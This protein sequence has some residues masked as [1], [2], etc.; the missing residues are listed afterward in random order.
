VG[1][2]F[3]FTGE[4]ADV[5]IAQLLPLG[6]AGWAAQLDAMSQLEFWSRPIEAATREVAAVVP[7]II[8]A[9]VLLLAVLL[10]YRVA[11]RVLLSAMGKRELDPGLRELL[12]RALK[13]SVMGFGVTLAA[14]QAGV[15][16]TA[17]LAGFSMAGT[18]V[19]FA[20]EETLANFIA[21]ITIA[22]D[23]PFRVGEKIGIGDAIGI[24][25]KITFRST[26]I[27]VG[28]DMIVHPNRF[29]TSSKI[30]N[31]SYNRTPIVRVKIRIDR[32]ESIDR[33]RAILLSLPLGDKTVLPQPRPRV[34]VTDINKGG[35]ELTL[36]FH[37]SDKTIPGPSGEDYLERTKKAFAEWGVRIQSDRRQLVLEPSAGADAIRWIL[38]SPPEHTPRRAIA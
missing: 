8:V 29:M 6:Q 14:H 38:Q 11:R 3:S 26:R 30:V 1:F 22:W 37:Y 16:I 36:Q 9:I 24:V 20:A 15:E 5:G 27:L 4:A 18:A 17:L 25:D 10:A 19:G 31:Y 21:A 33:A 7:R 28:T 23:K 32:D 35:V 12:A 2:T 13:W 34:I